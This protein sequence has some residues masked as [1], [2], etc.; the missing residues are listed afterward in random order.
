MEPRGQR[1]M[2]KGTSEARRSKDGTYVGDE[3]TKLFV[4]IFLKLSGDREKGKRL[5]RSM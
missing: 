4:F 5:I 1:E 2:K 3:R